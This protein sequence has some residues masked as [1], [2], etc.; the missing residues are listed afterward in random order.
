[1]SGPPVI[2]VDNASKRYG[3]GNTEVVAL[4]RA[5]IEMR[6]GELIGLVGPSGSGKTTFLMIAGLLDVPTSGMVYSRGQ[7]ISG[8]RTNLN[9]LRDFRRRH[10]GF[11][12][13]KPN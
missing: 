10:I 9:T 2:A 6:A 13:Q 11:V 4:D 7:V 5:T 3:A 1:M 12:F 8:P